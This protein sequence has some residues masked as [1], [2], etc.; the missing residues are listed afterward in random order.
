MNIKN[1][2]PNDNESRARLRHELDAYARR[3]GL[4]REQLV[5]NI[6]AKWL[7]VMGLEGEPRQLPLPTTDALNRIAVKARD[8]RLELL[9]AVA[10]RTPKTQPPPMPPTPKRVM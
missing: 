7:D 10:T 4:T 6:C 9:D 5:L 3:W 1:N 2:Y 8:A